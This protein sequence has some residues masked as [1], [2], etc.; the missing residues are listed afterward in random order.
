MREVTGYVPHLLI[1]VNPPMRN[2]RDMSSSGL[3]SLNDVVVEGC[4]NTTACSK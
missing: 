2:P 1:A 3:V 4:H